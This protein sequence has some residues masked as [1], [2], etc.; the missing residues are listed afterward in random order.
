VGSQGRRKKITTYEKKIS[1]QRVKSPEAG[2]KGAKGLDRDEE[3]DRKKSP[4]A[5]N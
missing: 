2:L 1:V 3:Y 4:S 5:V